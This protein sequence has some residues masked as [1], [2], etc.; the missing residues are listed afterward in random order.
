MEGR[1]GEWDWEGEKR[2][3]SPHTWKKRLNPRANICLARARDQRVFTPLARVE[4]RDVRAR[5]CVR[6]FS[7]HPV[8]LQSKRR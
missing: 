3:I 5:V 1:R 4:I 6:S 8:P 7:P 2:G